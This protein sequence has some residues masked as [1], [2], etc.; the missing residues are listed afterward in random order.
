[1]GIFVKRFQEMTT[2][3]MNFF[4]FEQEA[5]T[6]KERAY[7][8]GGR[9]LI[10]GEGS[11]PTLWVA[12]RKKCLRKKLI[13]LSFDFCWNFEDAFLLSFGAKT[14]ASNKI[15]LKKMRYYKREI[16]NEVNRIGSVSRRSQ[17]FGEVNRAKSCS[18]TTPTWSSLSTSRTSATSRWRKEQCWRW[19]FERTSSILIFAV[20]TNYDVILSALYK[21]IFED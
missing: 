10:E 5:K 6:G 3:V 16:K 13:A 12:T 15:N 1:M 14:K 18:K 4:G 19:R 9:K 21:I 2:K 20:M 8:F 7:W 11:F 17:D